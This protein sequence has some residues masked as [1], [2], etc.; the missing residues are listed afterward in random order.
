M[1][2]ITHALL[3]NPWHCLENTTC[4]ALLIKAKK[5]QEGKREEEFINLEISFSKNSIINLQ[6]FIICLLQSFLK[7]WILTRYNW[8][9]QIMY[10]SDVIGTKCMWKGQV[11][12]CKV[13]H[14]RKKESY[15]HPSAK[16]IS[17]YLRRA[18]QW[19]KQLMQEQTF[20]CAN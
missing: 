13:P 4:T 14:F 2:S 11:N 7:I 5:K 10:A 18:V 15:N 1:T 6:F 8:N 16:D 17:I 3:T 20:I 9:Y 12:N 19:K